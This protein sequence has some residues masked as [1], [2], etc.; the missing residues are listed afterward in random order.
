VRTRKRHRDVPQFLDHAVQVPINP[1]P[2]QFISLQI[3]KSRGNTITL[4]AIVQPRRRLRRLLASNARAPWP[5]RCK[6]TFLY[7]QVARVL[8]VVIYVQRHIVE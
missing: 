5:R 1:L 7:L 6:K 8:R 3:L 2:G 4:I